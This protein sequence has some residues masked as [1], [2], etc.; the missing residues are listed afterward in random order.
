MNRK[1][2]SYTTRDLQKNLVSGASR[3][4]MLGFC[5]GIVM[6]PYLHHDPAVPFRQFSRKWAWFTTK[7]VFTFMPIIGVSSALYE[8]GK[9]AGIGET[10]A[11][12]LSI[13]VTTVLFDKGRRFII[14]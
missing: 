3:G 1:Q 10:G 14:K 13:G 9:A 5:W 4:G 8:F 6:A 11:I 7:S 12:L 2:A